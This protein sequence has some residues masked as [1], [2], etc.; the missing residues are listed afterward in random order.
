MAERMLLQECSA[1]AYRFATA[2][3]AS[4]RLRLDLLINDFTYKAYSEGYLVVYEKH[5][6][7]TFIHVHD[8]GRAFLFGIDNVDKMK[9]QIYNI[10]SEKMNYSKKDICELINTIVPY[11][12]HYAD[13][14]EDA[15]KR[16]YV[17]SYNK[18]N[19]LGYTTEITI[20]EGIKELV[21]VF[22]AITFTTPYANV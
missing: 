11:Y 6:M 7:R 21:R 15:D 10:G 16:N 5:F 12:I 22:P 13:V 2:F 20:E 19:S 18:V 3:G 14:G 17:V 4:P 8:M 9:G 1:I